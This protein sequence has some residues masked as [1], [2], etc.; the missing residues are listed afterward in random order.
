MSA[1]QDD[2][3]PETPAPKPAPTDA[4]YRPTQADNRAAFSWASAELKQK[5]RDALRAE[6]QTGEPSP[7]RLFGAGFGAIGLGEALG[8]SPNRKME[9]LEAT[10][11]NLTDRVQALEESE[12]SKA[13][14]A[15][16][17]R[18]RR[19]QKFGG[20]GVKKDN[21]Y[22]LDRWEKDVAHELKMEGCRRDDSKQ[23]MLD[24][25]YSLKSVPAADAINERY[26]QFNNGDDVVSASSLR[27]RHPPTITK[28]AGG[29]DI[30]VL[31]EHVCKRWGQWGV[32][33]KGEE[34]EDQLADGSNKPT[35]DWEDGRDPEQICRAAEAYA[36][37]T[38]SE[39]N[40]K[41]SLLDAGETGGLQIATRRE[42]AELEVERGRLRK[43]G[44]GQGILHLKA[45]AD[46]ADIKNDR[47][48]QMANDYFREM[49][50]DPNA[51]H[52]PAKGGKAGG[53]G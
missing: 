32:F 28:N 40:R 22:W 46:E 17:R 49:G 2:L 21:D 11:I 51:V 41:R 12:A 7:A 35:M 42:L 5:I 39:D 16:P 38:D 23:R 24:R 20:R 10:Q 9:K 45:P 47:E 50:L 8:L 36:T 34:P 48:E 3:L 25:V 19:S 37:T 44:G 14:Q 31:G 33:R 29:K 27:R 4:G 15:K 18:Q 26:R 30:K 52:Q 43:L 13:P 53:G 6:A 1:D